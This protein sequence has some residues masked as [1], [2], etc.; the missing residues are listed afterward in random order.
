MNAM[1]IKGLLT[2]TLALLNRLFLFFIHAKLE[3]LTQFPASK[4]EY[5]LNTF[6]TDLRPLSI[7]YYFSAGI[8]FRRI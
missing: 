7:F 6:V 1:D 5:H 4:D 2:L 3:L 8:D